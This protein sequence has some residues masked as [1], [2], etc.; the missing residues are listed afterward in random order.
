MATRRFVALALVSATVSACSVFSTVPE[1]LD[2][3][4][5]AGRRVPGVGSD[6]KPLRPDIAWRRCRKPLE[7]GEVRMPLDH[8]RPNGRKIKL[9]V[10]RLPAPAKADRIGSLVVNPGG[11]GGSGVDFV[12][13]G[14]VDSVPAEVRARFDIVGFDPRGVGKS[15]AVECGSEAQI[16]LAG[17]LVPDDFGD[18]S[19]VLTR[20]K[21]P[22][23]RYLLLAYPVLIPVA[24]LLGPE[25]SLWGSPPAL[26]PHAAV[27]S[28]LHQWFRGGCMKFLRAALCMLVLATA[29]CGSQEQ[30][31]SSCMPAYPD[32]CIYGADALSCDRM[33]SSHFLAERDPYDLDTNGDRAACGAG[34]TTAPTGAV[35]E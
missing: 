34:D 13:D 15:D 10:I 28:H 27:C 20:A 31:A 2:P 35:E 22:R 16:S 12:R 30:F 21:A 3:V 6:D 8:R 17:D 9:A 11:P 29:A 4:D 5:S 14:A 25:R 7:C 23:P 18:V 26:L 1:S 24:R 19:A 33:T 32:M